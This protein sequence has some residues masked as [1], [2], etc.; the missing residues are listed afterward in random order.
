M[1]VMKQ[2]VLAPLY[3]AYGFNL[4]LMQMRQKCSKARVIG[5]ARLP[6]Y[7]VGF[8]EYTVVW[9]G[10]METIIPDSQS[11]VWGVL[12]ALSASEWEE[13][14]SHEDARAD[15]SGAY[16]HFPVEVIAADGNARQAM[17]FLKARLGKP[18]LPGTEYMNILLQGAEEQGLPPEY[19]TQLRQIKSK[20]AAYAVPKR[21][22]SGRRLIAT[23]DCSSCG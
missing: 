17:V 8:Y 5:I 7:K 13:L 23:G 11:Q 2:T 9:D 15:G 6:G 14:D 16:F 20:P 19:I 10:A 4:N 12:Y 21:P 18:E 3:F 1:H 22:S